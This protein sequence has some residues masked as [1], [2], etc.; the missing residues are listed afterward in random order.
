MSKIKF[1]YFDVGDV[2]FEWRVALRKIAIMANKSYE[3]VCIIFNKYDNDVCRGKISAQQLWKNLR[4]ELEIKDDIR[5]F[6]EWWSNSFSPIPVMHEIVK[7]TARKYKIGIL[8]NIYQGAWAY[9]VADKLIPDVSYVAII[10]SCNV[11]FVKPETELYEYAEKKAGYS[12]QEILLIDNSSE[13]ISKAREL[14]WQAVW[15]D[16][17][18]PQKSVVE[19]R[20]AL[21]LN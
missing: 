21:G 14:G 8:T 6:L 17:G 18:N 9:Y 1:V 20:Q 13:N 2:V 19:I 3:E 7:E 10:Q 12:S 5:N 16:V 11:G 15:Y 4:E